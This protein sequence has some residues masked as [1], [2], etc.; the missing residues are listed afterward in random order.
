MNDKKTYK[1]KAVLSD[2]GHSHIFINDVELPVLDITVK[3]GQEN[4]FLPIVNLM[5]LGGDIELEGGFQVTDNSK[6][7]EE[8]LDKAVKKGMNG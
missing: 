2:K 7:T 4:S 6:D 5:L 8:I 3:V 1:L